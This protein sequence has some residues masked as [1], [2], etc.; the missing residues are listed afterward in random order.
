MSRQKNRTRRIEKKVVLSEEENRMIQT[1]MQKIGSHNFSL[2]A[3]KMLCDGYL[4]TR[5][6]TYLKQTAREL[7]RIAQNLNMIAKRANT[8]QNIYEDDLRDIA[9]AYKLAKA[10]IASFITDLVNEEKF[11]RT[12]DEKIEH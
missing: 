11:Y 8:T 10:Q 4:I 9:R 3:R 6:F 12:Q 2:Y 1:N 7:G 5:D